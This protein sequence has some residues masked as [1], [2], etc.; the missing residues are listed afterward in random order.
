MSGC[1]GHL[2]T[3]LRVTAPP[4]ASAFRFPMQMAL[5]VR[6]GTEQ[7]KPPPLGTWNSACYP[8][9][10]LGLLEAVETLAL[11]Q[12]A[13]WFYR[14]LIPQTTQTHP[15]IQE[16]WRKTRVMGVSL[17][18]EGRFLGRPQKEL[19]NLSQLT[20][21][22]TSTGYFWRDHGEVREPPGSTGEVSGAVSMRR[23][24]GGSSSTWASLL[25]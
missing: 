22:K 7:T 6:E 2:G 21:C 20:S 15:G 24:P 9:R 13:D 25:W 23:L 18:P 8:C 1:S 3:G 12:I 19:W 4:G 10:C 14:V 11:D 16:L 17:C 5:G